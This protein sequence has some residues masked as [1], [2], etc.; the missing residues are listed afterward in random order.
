MPALIRWYQKW[1]QVKNDISRPN[2]DVD[3][4]LTERTTVRGSE[5]RAWHHGA[6]QGRN[7]EKRGF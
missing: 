1:P 4:L 2:Y 6:E 5:L 3:V 7:F